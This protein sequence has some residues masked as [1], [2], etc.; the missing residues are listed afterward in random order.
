MTA[1]KRAPKLRPDVAETAFRVYQEAIAE[2]PKTLPPT[3]RTE[4]NDEA[5]RRG[6]LGGKK[7]GRAR[8]RTLTKSK[9]T[10]IAKKGAAA[11]WKK[12]RGED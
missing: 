6:A 4:K 12:A 3:E 11:R 5:V 7:G 1:K 9:R 2:A 8:A 10:N